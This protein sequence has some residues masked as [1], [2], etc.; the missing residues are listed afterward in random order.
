MYGF[1]D[2][3][4][5]KVE[6]IFRNDDEEEGEVR[7]D[8][9]G[10]DSSATKKK[11]FPDL[12]LDEY[13]TRKQEV[14]KIMKSFTDK[15]VVLVAKDGSVVTVQ[16]YQVIKELAKQGEDISSLLRGSMEKYVTNVDKK[17]GEVTEKSVFVP[18]YKVY[19][20]MTEN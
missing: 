2:K 17:K 1:L 13:A 8:T 3:N 5:V 7:S 18:E 15:K 16:Q 14:S 6:E 9:A 19:R 10:E 12:Q 4:P 20:E 11:R